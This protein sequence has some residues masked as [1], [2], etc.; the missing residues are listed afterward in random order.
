VKKGN[1]A[2]ARWSYKG[3]T[4]NLADIVSEPERVTEC[5]DKGH[6]LVHDL[7]EKNLGV[8]EKVLNEESDQG[9]ELIQCHY[10]AGEMF[11]LWKKQ[12]EEA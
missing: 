1:T 6:C 4:H 3:S 8:L 9:W 2:M 10:H 7:P 5:D 11:C 12:E